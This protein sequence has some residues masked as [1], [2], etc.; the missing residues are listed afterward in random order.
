LG[1]VVRIGPEVFTN[2]DDDLVDPATVTVTIKKPDGATEDHPGV[3]ESLGTFYYD[4]TPVTA[5][6]YYYKWSTTG[7]AYVAHVSSFQVQD[8]FANPVWSYSGDPVATPKDTVRFLLGDTDPSD[9]LLSDQA[10]AFLITSW[11]NVY[12]AAAAGAEQ[13]AGQFAREVTNSGDGV[14]IDFDRLQEKYM[15]LAGQL[16]L[17]AKR[18]GRAASPYV[19]GM[20]KTETERALMDGD[21]ELTTFGTGMHDIYRD[22]ASGGDTVGQRLNKLKSDQ[23]GG[24]T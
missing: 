17:L 23:S 8:T 13:I 16:R 21:T 14:T 9:P 6:T 5:G 24:A 4:F 15:I 3:R 10:I 7:T 11:V 22:G 19:G 1:S 12:S 2:I 18:V 20:S